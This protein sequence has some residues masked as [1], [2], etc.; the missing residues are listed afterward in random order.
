MRFAMDR[1]QEVAWPAVPDDGLSAPAEKYWDR[2][3]PGFGLNLSPQPLRLSPQRSRVILPLPTNEQGR[4]VPEVEHPLTDPRR[5]QGA[6]EDW[7]FKQLYT[8]P[9]FPYPGV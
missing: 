8:D 2:T 5:G 3:S 4:I 7:Q 1:I 6:L 9:E